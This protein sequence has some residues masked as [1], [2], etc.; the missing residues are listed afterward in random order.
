MYCCA[1][2]E[3]RQEEVE[4]GYHKY[5]VVLQ[6][7]K[8][9]TYMTEEKLKQSAKLTIDLVEEMKKVNNNGMELQRMKYG[10]SLQ[11]LMRFGV[12]A[13]HGQC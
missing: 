13:G 6:I 8:F 1:V 10:N 2:R 3:F 12:L 11:K 7:Y 5:E 4:P 9:I